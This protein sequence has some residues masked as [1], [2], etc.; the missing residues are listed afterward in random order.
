MAKSRVAFQANKIHSYFSQDTICLAF[1]ESKGNPFFWSAVTFAAIAGITRGNNVCGHS[2]GTIGRG[3]RYKVICRKSHVFKQPGRVSAIS[4]AAMPILKTL[5]P[6]RFGELI[7]EIELSRSSSQRRCITRSLILFRIALRPLLLSLF[8][9]FAVL[10]TVLP[11]LRGVSLFYRLVVDRLTRLADVV[12]SQ[13]TSRVFGEVFR[14]CRKYYFAFRASLLTFWQCFCWMQRS[15]YGLDTHAVFTLRHQSALD[16]FRFVKELDGCR[17]PLF[18]FGT[19][20]DGKRSEDHSLF[21]SSCLP[22]VLSADGGKNR[23]SGISLADVSI[24]PHYKT[25]RNSSEVY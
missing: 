9:F 7:E 14:S 13:K 15:S 6:V 1:A 22:D 16:P 8:S 17:K 10:S 20:F 11:L 18:A 3:D 12:Y 25:L 2:A 23:F 5:A 19:T 24:I 4:T 21:T